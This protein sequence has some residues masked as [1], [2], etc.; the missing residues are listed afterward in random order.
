MQTYIGYVIDS[1]LSTITIILPD[2]PLGKLK[3]KLPQKEKILHCDFYDTYELL[4][5]DLKFNKKGD[6]V[7][8]S[9]RS[10]YKATEEHKLMA[11]FADYRILAEDLKCYRL[12]DH[13]LLYSRGSMDHFTYLASLAN[14]EGFSR[15]KLFIKDEFIY[16]VESLRNTNN[17]S[18]EIEDTLA[19]YLDR[20]DRY[21]IHNLNEEYH[22]SNKMSLF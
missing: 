19:K 8:W 3:H 7:D 6:V 15:I 4:A 5:F 13:K 2:K 18:W 16:G 14:V 12:W 17:D 11:I 22:N 9:I 21:I 20:Y 10:P 1:D